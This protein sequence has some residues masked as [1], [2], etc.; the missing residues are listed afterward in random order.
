[1]KKNQ[2]F[3]ALR[4]AW[5]MM[6]D[7]PF[8]A[9]PR[10]QAETAVSPLALSLA[11]PAAGMLLGIVPV[12]VFK[13]SGL[14]LPQFGNTV[15]FALAMTMLVL[16]ADSGRG[17]RLWLESVRLKC[18]GKPLSEFLP[19]FKVRSVPEMQDM[20]SSVTGAV[21][22]GFL[23]FGF[24]CLANC[25]MLFWAAPVLLAGTTVQGALLALPDLRT[26]TPFLRLQEQD[27]NKIWGIAL[28]L[29]LFPAVFQPLA[30]LISAGFCVA[31]VWLIGMCSEK[32]WG[33]VTEEIITLSGF[34]AGL[35]TLFAGV[36]FGC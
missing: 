18:A 24:G 27:R 8:P 31:E 6:F 29:V 13:I 12:I 5:S 20:V 10:S 2:L 15:L 25:G 3:S 11:V 35:A 17:F 16:F 22:L 30:A 21:T 9:S 4:E 33:G 19:L 34:L 23:L 32:E 1:M 14:F 26:G 36:I 28:F 7:L